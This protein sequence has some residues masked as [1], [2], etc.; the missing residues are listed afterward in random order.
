V[1][2]DIVPAY[3]ELS[4]SEGT[5]RP[6]PYGQCV[7]QCGGQSA[8]QL[9]EAALKQYGQV[10]ALS[11]V[12]LFAAINRHPGTTGERLGQSSLIEQILGVIGN[13]SVDG[14][15]A[16]WVS[17]QLFNLRESIQNEAG[18]K[19]IDEVS[20]PVFRVIPGTVFILRLKHEMQVPFRNS[21]V[22]LL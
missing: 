15:G 18:M 19:V 5:I 6:L 9:S 7:L 22:F 4:A 12:I 21:P 11:V 17:C 3:K 20:L 10:N 16:A 2:G 13:P 1:H 8:V 14:I